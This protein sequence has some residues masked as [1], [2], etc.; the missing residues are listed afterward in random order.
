MNINLSLYLISNSFQMSHPKKTDFGPGGE[1]SFFISIDNRTIGVADGVGGW[2]KHEESFSHKWSHSIMEL[3]NNFTLN[4][5][6]PYEAVSMSYSLLDKTIVGSTTASLAQLI[7]F[8]EYQ[9][10]KGNY[11]NQIPDENITDSTA[12]VDFYSIGDSLCSAIRP[13]IG[14]LFTTNKTSHEFNFPYQ[15]GSRQV[16]TVE[17]GT[18]EVFPVE[19]GDFI[20]CASD[21]VWDNLFLEQIYEIIETQMKKFK[22][23]NDSNE[24]ELHAFVKETARQI[25]R[26]SYIKGSTGNTETPFS[27]GAAKAGLDFI[28]G[29]LDDTTAVLSYIMKSPPKIN[30]AESEGIKEEL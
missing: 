22:I 14:F 26:R 7:S 19:Q 24:E 16:S 25:V 15:L 6:S 21:G 8:S 3:C 10:R 11:S 13:G 1:D 28:G 2:K 5:Y 27:N 4:G 18:I 20:L 29:K 23:S 30:N 12:F 17:D 9:Q